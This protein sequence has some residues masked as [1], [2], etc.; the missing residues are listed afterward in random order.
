MKIRSACE[1]AAIALPTAFLLAGCG[2]AVSPVAAEGPIAAERVA[3]ERGPIENHIVANGHVVA[4]RM[5]TLTFNRGG[6][7]AQVNAREGEW[8]QQ[9]QLL[10]KL[11]TREL[12]LVAKQQR[13]NYLHALAQYS[14]TLRGGSAFDIRQAQS[15]L[16]S[17]NQRLKDLDNGPS[18][19]QVA[20]LQAAVQQAEAEVKR[21]QSAYD[22]AYRSAPSTITA[23]PEAADLELKTIALQAARARLAAAREKPQ[24]GQYA[25]IRAQSAAAQAKLGAL[26]PVSETI[27]SQQALLDQAYY[28]WQQAELGL[29]DTRVIAPFDGLVTS[30]VM[31]SGDS[32]DAS[33][34]IQ[35]ADFAQPIFEADVDEA[36]LAK[37]EVGQAARVRLQTY[38]DTPIDAAVTSIGK[39]GRQNGSLI[40]YRVWLKL[41]AAQQE[42]TPA[43]EPAGPDP[44]EQA[45]A[46]PATAPAEAQAGF[47]P[48]E[49]SAPS[50]EVSA[51]PEILL[52]MSGSAQ[53]VTASSPDALLVPT[54]ALI[55]DP[56]TQTYSVQIVRGDGSAQVSE[57]VEV[58]LGLRNR[59][60]VEI[61]NGVDE[62]DLIVVPEPDNVPLEGP[63][64]N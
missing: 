48:D 14:Q 43:D 40:V 39:V 47:D 9:G 44:D 25:E 60:V 64:V 19:A 4:E 42:A 29:R 8:V 18:L 11:D 21:A 63:S 34:F 23:S 55:L 36:D 20:E 33:K 57:E 1:L 38:L 13:A 35:V 15:E 59:D 10:A 52:N 62:G 54:Q 56:D 3:V 5:A 61:I 12:E 24:P 51:A 2:G 6:R 27:L 17:A 53:F 30:V 46:E 26:R 37:I 32:A 22:T 45:A 41:G 31:A 7:I 16:A 58:E 49:Q 28:A 50:D